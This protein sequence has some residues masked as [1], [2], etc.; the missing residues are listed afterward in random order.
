MVAAAVLRF[1]FLQIGAWQALFLVLSLSL[2]LR[3][4]RLPWLPP[5]V[6]LTASVPDCLCGSGPAP[7]GKLKLK[8]SCS[9]SA[10]QRKR[11]EEARPHHHCARQ[12]G[13]NLVQGCAVLGFTPFGFGTA[14][15]GCSH[16][17]GYTPLLARVLSHKGCAHHLPEIVPFKLLK[18]ARL[19][20]TIARDS[21]I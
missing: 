10:P 17:L 1:V 14:S 19:D 18:K 9:E 7:G 5:A 13:D 20:S 6:L 16:K 11:I 15:S 2:R 21:A 12:I 4:T 3:S 8:P